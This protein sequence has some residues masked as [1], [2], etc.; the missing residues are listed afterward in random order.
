MS[1]EQFIGAVA[2]DLKRVAA[3]LQR[4]SFSMAEEL[5]GKAL[6]TKKHI[7]LG[8]VESHIRKMLVDI[9]NISVNKNHLQAAEIALMYGTLLQ[10]YSLSRLKR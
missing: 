1:T 10:N 4:G 9:D 2:M 8:K 6:A 7:E 5:L 3:S